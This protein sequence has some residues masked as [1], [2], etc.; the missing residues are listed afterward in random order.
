MWFTLSGPQAEHHTRVNDRFTAEHSGI[1]IEQLIVAEADMT[2]KLAAALAG[3]RPPD[4]A[5]FG[6][7]ARIAELIEH[8]KVVSLSRYRRDLARLDWNDAFKR[9]V[10]RGDD[11]Y[12]MPVQAATLALFYNV[13]LYQRA[14]LDPNRPPATWAEL[15][16]TAKAI[17]R[18]AQQV[19]GHYIGTKPITWTADQVWIA[20]LWQAGGEWLSPDG[21]Q[22]AFNSDAGVEALQFWTDLVQTHQ[23]AP[24]KAVDNLIM[25]GDFETGTV[26]HMTLYA[27]W[28]IRAEG[29]KFPVRTA[30]LPRHRQAA[31]VTGIA[32]VPI[33]SDSKQRD[34][35]WRYLD[36][37]SQPE[38]LVFYLSGFGSTPPRA[39]VAESAAWKAFAAQHP[40]LQAFADGQPH[41]RLPYFGKGA[42]EIAVQVAQ[43]IEAA[44]FKQKPPRQAL[45]DAARQANAILAR[46]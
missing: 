5:T 26:G 9:V 45:D 29:M 46:A 13:E 2:A 31:T 18:P 17:A 41:G 42:Q 15:V 34:A 8:K 40:L 10:V 16:A 39:S 14:G 12:A 37:L 33:F 24:P 36:W 1:R 28:A 43:A 38:N 32:T 3:G 7:A 44:V 6:G 19:W 27:P 35:A 20:Y 25:G 21:K 22:A 4:L 30:L 23:V 11:L